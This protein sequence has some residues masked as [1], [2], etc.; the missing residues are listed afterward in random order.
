[1]ILFVI[2]PA[3][4][5]TCLPEEPRAQGRFTVYIFMYSWEQ[6]D[7]LRHHSTVSSDENF[8]EKFKSENFPFFY[9]DS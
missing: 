1:M 2:L 4:C 3:N 5:E 8:P 9:K 7:L 6:H